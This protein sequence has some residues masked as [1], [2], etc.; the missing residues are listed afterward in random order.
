MQLQVHR[1][2]RKVSFV[3]IVSPQAVLENKGEHHD[4]AS[5]NRCYAHVA[6][7]ILHF[8]FEVQEADLVR[9]ALTQRQR[10]EEQGRFADPTALIKIL[11][12]VR[13]SY[14]HRER[15]V[16]PLLLKLFDFRLHSWRISV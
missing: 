8:V 10:I 6:K 11:E 4:K 16:L 13:K 5:E 2:I 1:Y 3:L 14:R 7:I 12:I 9:L 15:F